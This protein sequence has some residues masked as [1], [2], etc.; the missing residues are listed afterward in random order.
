MEAEH[1]VMA[2]KRD[3]SILISTVI[4]S[5]VNIDVIIAQLLC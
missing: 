4:V 5:L 2:N 3:V 1:C